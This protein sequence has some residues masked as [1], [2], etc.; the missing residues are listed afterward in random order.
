[1]SGGTVIATGGRKAAGIG[2]GSEG[3]AGTFSTGASGTAFIVASGIA[4]KNS[5]SE[6]N[7]IIFDGSAGALYGVSTL[8][9]DAEIPSG[10]TLTIKAGETL[11]I[12][13]GKTLTIAEGGTLVNNGTL[14]N[15]GILANSG[16]L[17]NTATYDGT[18]TLTGAG[19]VNGIDFKLGSL[20]IKGAI[21]DGNYACNETTHTL[22]ILSDKPLTISGTTTAD[23]IVVASG[24]SANITLDS[25]SIDVSG[26]SDAC[27]FDMTGATVNLV[28]KDATTNALKSSRAKAALLVPTGATL[29]ISGQGT[30]EAIGNN[31]AAGIGGGWEV[32]CGKV[33]I[34]EGTVIATADDEAAGIGGGGR[35]GAGGDITISGGTVIATGGINAA[36]IGGGYQGRAGDITISGGTVIATGGRK[37]AGI[38]G[39]SEGAA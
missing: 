14:T 33:T 9:M 25:V 6:W 28:L 5:Q 18:G 12:D 39:G 7:G 36:G 32:S 16:T 2:G 22:T 34:T 24:V 13:S 10:Y 23:K 3:A 15:N 8:S 35:G 38:G 30:L 1:I 31:Q 27:A 19:T 11:T 37:A 17:T 29:A 20:T 21:P 26:I 4:D